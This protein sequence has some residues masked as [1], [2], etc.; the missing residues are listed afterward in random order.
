MS[1]LIIPSDI[2]LLPALKRIEEEVANTLTPLTVDMSDVSFPLTRDVFLVM[3][4]RFRTDQ[5]H[6]L[7][8]HEYEVDMARSLGIGAEVSWVRAEFDREFS[9]KNILSHNFTMWEYFLYEMRRGWEYVRFLF[10]RKRATTPLYKIKKWSPNMFLIVSGLIMSLSLLLFIF[11]FA[12][13]KTYVS[14][15]PQTTVRPVS[16]NMIFSSASGSLLESKNTVRMKKVTLFVEE[17]MPFTLDTIDPNSATNAIGRV[18]L[19][20]ELTTEQAL[21]PFT[22]FITEDGVVFRTESWVNIPPARKVNDIT[23]IGSVEA[24]LKADPSD[25]GGK[26]IGE[27]GNIPTWAYLSIPGLKF[28]RDKVYGKAKEN[29]VWGWP[30]RIHLVTEPEVKKFEWILREQLSRSARAKLQEWLDEQ[31]KNSGESFTLL[32]WDS[33]S[34]TGETHAITSGQKIGDLANEIEMKGSLTVTAL[35]YDKKSVIDYL[36]NLFHERLLRGTDKELA[37]HPDTLRMT[38][39]ISRAEDGSSIKATM[40]MNTTITYDLENASNE[41]TR[42]MKITIAGLT[43]KEAIDR[44]INEWHVREVDVSF[45]PFWLTRV[46][47]NLD[48]IEFIIKK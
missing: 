1:K 29:F 13:S 22:R 23:E 44:L 24:I 21:K 33:V 14:V 28:N 10:T 36:T 7:L 8:R 4:K 26:V 2:T 42:R 38:N 39:V 9:K 30:A 34:F 43:K 31:N 25:E 45:S 47:S 41:L 32:S 35:V 11:Y 27:R 3:K 6:L 37:I 16:A 20:N 5:F 12:V 46:S 19:Y 48:N 17:R 40:E 18:T 15:L